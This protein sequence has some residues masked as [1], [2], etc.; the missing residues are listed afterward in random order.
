MINDNFYYNKI[1]GDSNQ[2]FKKVFHNKWLSF[3]NSI[4]LPYSN[5]MQLRIGS[6]LRPLLV[7]WGAAL[8]ADNRECSLT[9]DVSELAICVEILHK[10][11]IIID[12]L[13][14][15]DIKRH[16]QTT[17]HIQYTPEETIIFAVYMMGKAFEKINTLSLRYDNLNSPLNNIYAK[18]IQEMATGCL[19]ELSL[20]IEKKYNYEKVVSIICQE[21]STLIKNSLL[22]GFMTNKSVMPDTIQ[23]IEL[24]GDKVGFL[25]QAMNDLEPFCSNKNLIH[26]KGI[27]NMDFEHSRKNIVL[28]YI[29]GSCSIHEKKQLL[30]SNDIEM[31][32]NLYKKHKIE[33]TIKNDLEKIESEVEIHF[34]KLE[35][36]QLNISCLKDFYLFYCNIIN[37]AKERLNNNS[38]EPID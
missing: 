36:M 19:S 33:M 17:F 5:A 24:I 31:I 35:E 21:T 20:S 32:L 3:L 9:D 23:I 26:H 28:P 29:Y 34:Q 37:I 38:E 16:N 13:I 15:H 22:M 8:G 2:S 18:T 10:T 27:L 4:E 7:Y 12:D 6:H 1:M 14:D 25:F 11:S 30:K